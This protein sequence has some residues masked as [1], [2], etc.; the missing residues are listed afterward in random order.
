[1]PRHFRARLVIPGPALAAAIFASVGSAPS[2][3]HAQVHWDASATAGPSLRL[4]SGAGA[5]ARPGG[6]VQLAAHT[7][8]LP[9]V[10]VGLALGGELEPIA[11]PPPPRFLG[12]AGLRVKVLSPWPSGTARVYLHVGFA[13]SLV[14]AGSFQPAAP[15]PPQGA[16]GG[17]FVEVPFGVGGQLR[18]WGPYAVVAEAAFRP[19]FAH[20]GSL[21]D[22]AYAAGAAE[23]V[24]FGLLVGI[25][26]DR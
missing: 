7:A 1:M 11:G 2:T 4:L 13:G 16:A 22:G 19:G 8:L 15:S 23:R 17:R 26:L 12:T 21:Y 24:G 20:G 14:H 9:L 6:A 25:M 5:E 18:V 3:S 10:R